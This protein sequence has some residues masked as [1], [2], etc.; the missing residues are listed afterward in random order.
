MASDL[1]GLMDSDE[2]GMACGYR[3]AGQ[4]STAGVVV[5]FGDVQQ[6]PEQTIDGETVLASV[7]QV[8]GHRPAL[9]TAIE[10]VV[11]AARDPKRDDAL[12]V[13]SGELAGTWVIESVG[14]DVGGGVEMQCR[15]ETRWRSAGPG[16]VEGG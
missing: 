7:C 1:S 4:G 9:R 15:R 8:I 3:P 12:V 14:Q 5:V 16:A 10:T 13:A 2:F 6:T 11:D